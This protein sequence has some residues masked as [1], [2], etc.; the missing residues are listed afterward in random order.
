MR[1][2]MLGVVVFF[3]SFCLSAAITQ[4][5]IDYGVIG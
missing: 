2:L 3:I 1:G 4:L 5:L